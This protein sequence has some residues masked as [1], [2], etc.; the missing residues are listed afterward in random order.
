MSNHSTHYAYGAAHADLEAVMRIAAVKR[1]HMIDTTRIQT[2][3]EHTAN[4]ALLAMVIAESA[5]QMYFGPGGFVA[6]AGLVH[7]I[8]E[9]FTG[10]IPSHTKASIN[11]PQLEELEQLVTPID[12]HRR[13]R[14]TPKHVKTLIKVCDIV[15]GIRFIRL[16]GVDVTATHAR[17]QIEAKL[18][19]MFTEVI[20]LWPRQVTVHVFNK[21][22]FYAYETR[23]A[24]AGTF[25]PEDVRALAADMARRQG[26]IPRGPGPVVRD[27]PPGTRN[28]VVGTESP[29]F[30]DRIERRERRDRDVPA[31]VDPTAF[32]EDSSALP[33]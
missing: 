27:E 4:V 21:A 22:F 13:I 31:P 26:D 8:P 7:D 10:D 12:M 17:L 20:E 9:V 28:G 5:P 3:A 23:I 11:N 18:W 29:A 33:D 2:L 24:D 15:D 30:A 14:D 6:A 32:D 19:K 1:W 25:V 16:H